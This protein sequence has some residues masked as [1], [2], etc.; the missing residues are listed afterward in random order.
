MMLQRLDHS[1]FS[2]VLIGDESL[3]CGCGD[4]LLERGCTIA[5]VISTDPDV[6]VWAAAHGIAVDSLSPGIEDRLAGTPFDWLFSIANLRIIPDP[7][8]RLPAQAAINFHDGPLP[9]YA[10]VNAP[11]WALLNGEREHGVTWHFIEGGIDEGRILK[12]RRFTLQGDETAYALNA[13][14]YAE[15]LESFGELLSEMLT[16][17]LEPVEQDLSQRSY[18]ERGR[19]PDGAGLIDFRKSAA[20]IA[21][22]V[23]ALD[24]GPHRNPVCRAKIVLAD[25]VAW[26]GGAEEAAGEGEPGKVLQAGDADITVATAA[27]AL[28]LTGLT[29]AE[30]AP[31]SVDLAGWV[32]RVLPVPDRAVQETLQHAARGEPYWRRRLAHARPVSLATASAARP[33]GTLHLSVRV[34]RAARGSRLLAA[35]AVWAW[36]SDGSAHADLAYCDTSTSRM[37]ASARH[38][39]S[40]WV[41][42]RAGSEAGEMPSFATFA[43]DIEAQL[44]RIARY[45]AFARGLGLRDPGIGPVRVP[46]IGVNLAETDLLP[47]TALTAV[48]DGNQVLL[49]GNGERIEQ[50]YFHILAERLETLLQA[51]ATCDPDATPIDALPILP[52][53][54]RGLLTRGLN[55]TERGYPRETTLHAAVE[56]Q[57]AAKPDAVALAFEADEITYAAL[58]ARANQLAHML[59][60]AGVRRG[61]RVGIHCARG[62]DMVVAALGAMKAGAAYVPLDPAYPADRTGHCLRDSGAAVVLT[63]DTLAESLPAT[64]AAV[65]AMD[66]DPRIASSPETSPGIAVSADDLAYLIYTSGSTGAPKGVA[67]RHRNIANFMAGMD[68]RLGDVENGVWLAVT[69]LSFDISVLEL[70]YTLARGYKVVLSGDSDRVLTSNAPIPAS[71]R[72]MEFSLFYWGNDDGVGPKKYEL[73]L[74]GAKFADAHGFCAVWTPERHFH[75]FGGPY[76]NPSVTGAAVAAVTRNIGVRAGSCVAPLHH[77]ARIAEEWAVVDNLTNGRAGLAIASGWQPDDFVLR[78]ENTPPENKPAMLRAIADLRK[79]W[80][81]EAVAFPDAKGAPQDVITQPRPVSKELPIWV[82]TA[83]NPETW[84]EAGSL[85]ANV[86]THLLGQSIEEV[87]EKIAIYH[88][89]LRTAG[90]DP[91]DRKVTLMLHTLVGDDRE[92]VR[93]TARGPMKDYLR[94]AAGL[95]KQYAWAFPAFKKPAGVS[96]PFQIDL[97][98]LTADEMDAILD[99]AFE[100]YFEESGLFGTVA[101]CAARVEALKGI[102]VDEIACLIDY[103]VA[104][105]TVMHSLHELAKVL[106][107]TNQEPAPPADFSLAAQ[108][109]RHGVTHLQCTPSMARMLLADDAARG[110]LARIG[111]LMVGGEAL[112]DALA[113]ELWSATG[114]RLLNMYGPTETTIWS[115][116]ADLTDPVAPV[117]IGTPIANTQAYVL[118]GEDR[119]A[120]VG[121]A[122]ELCLGGDGVTA[123]YWQR[124]ELTAAA[125]PPDPFA[126]AF[127]G[128]C[129]PMYRTGDLARWRADGQLEYLGR[130]DGQIKL[131]GHRIEPGEIEAALVTLPG[132]EEALVAARSA[133]DG[134]VRLAAYVKGTPPAEAEIRSRLERILPAHMV[135]A[136]YV[137]LDAFPLT[138]NRKIDRKALV[139]IRP[140]RPV[141]A[142]AASAP[143]GSETESRI[144]TIWSRVLGVGRIVPSDNFFALG[145]HSLLAIQAHREIVREIGAD[146]VAITDIFA[147]PTLRGLAARIDG[148]RTERTGGSTPNADGTPDRNAVMSGRRA[149]RAK[150]EVISG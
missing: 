119:P 150:R 104:T 30:G 9:R 52:E 8:L 139:A 99:F 80:R 134:D 148:R 147:H 54:E 94:S 93:Q 41:P 18:F 107:A 118:D 46:D 114:G 25:G 77:T 86:L 141:A 120:P 96:N 49:I 103:G 117:S 115:T 76:P 51:V 50:A 74:E 22:L 55:R 109:H 38:M 79:L 145:G 149:L 23:R 136:E 112:T 43:A 57:A 24:H 5:A 65:I 35:L 105:D 108:I 111:T 73:L 58:D 121:V 44:A 85:G 84:K 10:G 69:S 87:G 40:C 67:V 47:D 125:F 138:P 7:L 56:A 19:L 89:A 16:G 12:Q 81:G 126:E 53:A 60:E 140:R 29:D 64:G 100:R 71:G 144:A 32:H 123:G 28:R 75:A 26:V 132:I 68:D 42:L 78:P 45:P 101:D 143:G 91:A 63:Q 59:R 31:L 6:R 97:A 98:E 11:V 34:P 20:E 72:G 14:C 102:G 61:A 135:P 37:A 122:G 3:L 83:G 127:G 133:R 36:R 4:Q 17:T 15:G 124:D 27:G 116:V 142:P 66:S 92:T 130:I 95:I 48:P 70:F 21:T 106:A 1:G 113:A 137:T 88:A 82:T 2:A 90:H 110:A 128:T 131:R 33:G 62:P 13:R 129:P 146:R 39:L